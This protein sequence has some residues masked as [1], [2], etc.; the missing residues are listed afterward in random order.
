M[1]D[2]VLVVFISFFYVRM[3]VFL[4]VYGIYEIVILEF[5]VFYFYG[6]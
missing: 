6:L 3:Y 2:Y 1:E 5:Y 4:I